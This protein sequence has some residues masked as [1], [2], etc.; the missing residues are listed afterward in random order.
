VI[1]KISGTT[2]TGGQPPA[3]IAAAIMVDRATTAPTD[4]SMPPVRITKVMPTASTIR[5]ALST[6]R[7]STT[8][9][10]AKPV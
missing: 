2:T 5:Y 7:L 1:T 9:G 4:R 10:E 6:S 8:C 3:S